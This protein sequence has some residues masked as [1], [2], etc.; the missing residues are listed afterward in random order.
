MADWYDEPRSSPHQLLA[1]DPDGAQHQFEEGFKCH[2]GLAGVTKDNLM[3][4]RLFKLAA[5][6]GSAGAQQ[7]LGTMYNRGEGL[8][9]QN[10]EKAAEPYMLSAGGAGG[11]GGGG[12]AASFARDGGDSN[13]ANGAH[14][15]Q[16]SAAQRALR[17]S[18]DDDSGN[19]NG[20]DDGGLSDDDGGLSN[21]DG[22]LSDDEEAGQGDLRC[23]FDLGSMFEHGTGGVAKDLAEAAKLY[24]RAADNDHAPDYLPQT[25]NAAGVNK[26]Y[27]EEAQDRL[28]CL[29]RDGKGV[30]NDEQEAA[31]LFQLVV[32][33]KDSDHDGALTALGRMLRT[34][35]A[36]VAQDPKEAARLFML[37]AEMQNA[38]AQYYLGCMLCDAEGGVPQNHK[39][40]ARLLTLAAATLCDEEEGKQARS[41]LDAL[42]AANAEADRIEVFVRSSRAPLWFAVHQRQRCQA[43][44]AV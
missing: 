33:G 34:G 15:N 6:Q 13:G 31:R 40:A 17:S 11:I 12:D 2:H 29:L 5:A 32:A 30:Q 1:V 43:D 21:D 44:S 36:G 18:A 16:A 25:F 39:E 38:Y 37:A 3:A 9:P 22:G 28:G 42:T 7:E 20:N 10:K 24:R 27:C 19:D 14:G 8:L 23:E 26:Y 4:G 35:G 41:K